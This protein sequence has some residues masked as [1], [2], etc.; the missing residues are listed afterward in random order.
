M[1]A[2]S[3]LLLDRLLYRVIRPLQTLQS[4]I[5]S[6]ASEWKAKLS[7][8]IVARSGSKTFGLTNPTF[9]VWEDFQPSIFR[10]LN[11]FD[12]IVFSQLD[13]MILAYEFKIEFD[14]S[15][16]DLPYLLEKA[17]SGDMFSISEYVST[18][19]DRV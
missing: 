3:V 12:I 6:I 2:Y 16:T 10:S 17:R 15:H 8:W 19:L 18:R 4:F 1:C 9:T 14:R 11:A 7:I 13:S 5:S